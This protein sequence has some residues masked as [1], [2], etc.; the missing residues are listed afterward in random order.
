M[1]EKGERLVDDDD[2]D[3]VCVCVFAIVGGLY[4][5]PRAL[6]A[7]LEMHAARADIWYCFALVRFLS[8]PL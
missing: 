4:A 6:A 8:R 5:C 1:V 7:L 3:V 2:V